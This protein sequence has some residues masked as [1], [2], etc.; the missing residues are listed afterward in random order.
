MASARISCSLSS[1]KRF[2][3]CPCNRSIRLAAEA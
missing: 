2:T 3:W 1:A